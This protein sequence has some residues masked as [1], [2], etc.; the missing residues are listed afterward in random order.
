MLSIGLIAAGCGMIW[1][2]FYRSELLEVFG[3]GAL[4]ISM[5]IFYGGGACLGAGLFTPFKRPVTGAAIA[6]VIQNLLMF[7]LLR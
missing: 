6:M 3:D 7:S 4:G 5:M 1:F 2:F